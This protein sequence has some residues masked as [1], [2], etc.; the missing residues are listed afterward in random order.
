MQ[1]KTSIKQW[2][3]YGGREKLNYFKTDLSHDLFLPHKPHTYRHKTGERPAI[4]RLKHGT[5]FKV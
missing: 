2:W 1:T 4:N 5:N 3:N